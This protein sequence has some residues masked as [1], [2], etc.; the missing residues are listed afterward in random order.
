ML[1]EYL[2]PDQILLNE[3]GQDYRDMLQKMVARSAEQDAGGIVDEILAREKIMPTA[4]GKGIYLPRIRIDGKT[5][6]EVIIAVNRQGLR[7]EEYGSKVANIIMLFIF[8]RDD[9][10]AAILAQ[11][12]RLL[13]D[14]NLRATLLK[15]TKETEI[16]RAIS[17][18]EQA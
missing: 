15:C 16:I 17:D 2:R 9:D 6:S 4:L 3:G 5:G 11:S 14:D 10:H 7:F 1:A 13:N 8:S 18:W 12:L